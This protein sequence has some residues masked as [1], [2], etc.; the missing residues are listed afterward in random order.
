[1]FRLYPYVVNYTR[2]RDVAFCGSEEMVIA[3]AVVPPIAAILSIVVVIVVAFAAAGG[4]GT[5]PDAGVIG[6]L[7]ANF[8][9]TVQS[10]DMT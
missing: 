8:S 1:M 5:D 6:I 2:C 3:L 7:A 4:F 9:H 10:P